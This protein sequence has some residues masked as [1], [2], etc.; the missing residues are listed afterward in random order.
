MLNNR[1][2]KTPPQSEFLPDLLQECYIHNCS[3]VLL[4][5]LL[6]HFCWQDFARG[7]LY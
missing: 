4:Q 3:K 2:D 5:D 6:N 1:V 7:F